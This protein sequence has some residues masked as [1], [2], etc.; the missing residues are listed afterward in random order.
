MIIKINGLTYDEI[1][2]RIQESDNIIDVISNKI[3]NIPYDFNLVGNMVRNSTHYEIDHFNTLFD[4]NVFRTSVD[5]FQF[6]TEN[7]LNFISYGYCFFVSF[8]L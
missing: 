6:V 3:S 1:H 5:V 7:I 8:W 2:N 4:L